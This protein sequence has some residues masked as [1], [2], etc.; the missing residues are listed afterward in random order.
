M[1]LAIAAHTE[2][3]QESVSV[4]AKVASAAGVQGP[5]MADSTFLLFEVVVH[6]PLADLGT[7]STVEVFG[8][9][10]TAVNCPA[11]LKPIT[12]G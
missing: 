11:G 4:Q 5:P 7:C 2:F 10:T 8:R 3:L 6:V 12:G 9:G 1:K